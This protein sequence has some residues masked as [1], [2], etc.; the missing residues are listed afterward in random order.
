MSLVVYRATKLIHS[1]RRP[2]QA[3]SMPVV[4]LDRSRGT[5]SDVAYAAS[6]AATSSS[7][8]CSKSS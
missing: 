6:N 3:P 4:R 7:D 2:A 5:G 8:T 1:T